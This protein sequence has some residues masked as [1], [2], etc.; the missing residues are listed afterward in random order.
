M[1]AA[2]WKTSEGTAHR[3]VTEILPCL[4]EALQSEIEQPDDWNKV[5][6]LPPLCSS[7][8]LTTIV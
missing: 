2:T 1:L 5:N 7:F 3:A 4:C 8:V 6:L